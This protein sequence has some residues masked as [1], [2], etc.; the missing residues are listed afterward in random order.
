MKKLTAV[1]IAL[2]FFLT[3]LP[4][5]AAVPTQNIVQIASG[6]ADFSI[7]VEAV[8]AAGL[9]DDL[10]GTGPFT[11]FAPTNTAFAALLTDLGI[12]KEQLL[13]NPD[14]A[15]VL[16][17]HVVSGKVMS[18]NLV[19]DMEAATLQ[20]EKLAIDLTPTPPTVNGSKITTVDIEATNGV[21]HVI[22]KVLVPKA[23]GAPSPTV[24]EIALSNPDFSVLVAALQKANLVDALQGDGPFT[25]FAPTNAAFTALLDAL[26]ITAEELLAQPDLTKVLLHHVV[27]GKVMSGALTDGLVATTLNSDSLTFN[28]SG[29]PPKVDNASIVAVDI[30]AGNGVIHVIDSVLVPAGFTLQKVDE[31]PAIPKTGDSQVYLILGLL[32]AGSAMLLAVRRHSMR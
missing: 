3:T 6:N 25:V 31:T 20:G 27:S 13:A 28:L 26:D 10:A 30:E 19:D 1:I 12:T 5:M 29:T 23:F 9:D 16:L 14:L 11:V 2:A 22:D 21:I 32:I 7:L 24:V 18:A 15:K 8:V 17:Y 4:V